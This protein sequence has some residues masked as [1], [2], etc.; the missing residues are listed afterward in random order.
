MP[1]LRPRWRDAR[2]ALCCMAKQPL[3][4]NPL[5]PLTSALANEQCNQGT[6]G[7]F[8]S[9]Q[10]IF[11]NAYGLIAPS[12]QQAQYNCDIETTPT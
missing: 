10:L 6:V 2:I 1:L 12:Y 4:N 8:F 7:R 5:L 11:Q 9:Q 3:Q